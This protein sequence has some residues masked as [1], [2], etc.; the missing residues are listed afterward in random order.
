MK[1]NAL[2]FLPTIVLAGAAIVLTSPAISQSTQPGECVTTATMSVVFAAGTPRA[3]IDRVIS[4]IR[5]KELASG[6]TD[7]QPAGRWSLTSYGNTGSIGTACRF[8]YSFVPDGVEVPDQ[9]LGG[10]PSSLQGTFTGQFGS[11][12]LWKLK[13]RQMF[14]RW[15]ELS[16]L[17]Y[18]EVSDDGAPLHFFPG[19][20]GMRGDLRVA[21]IVMS[22]PNVLA[23]NFY[24][25]NGDMVV[26]LGHNWAV[27]GNDYRFMRNILGH[28]HGHGMG[29]AHVMPM[30]ETKLME[31]VLTVAFDG[32]QDDD[33]Q[34][35]QFLYG[36]I[37]EDND[38]VAHATDIGL[39]SSGQAVE[40]LAVERPAD[41]DWFRVEIPA[42]FN[43]TVRVEPVGS[44][45][46]VGPQGGTPR[47][48]NGR[49]VNNLRL[50][51]YSS[52]GTV[53]LGSSNVGGLGFPETLQSISRPASGFVTVKVDVSTISEDI[54]RYRLI[55][56][57]D[58]ATTTFSPNN[59]SVLI[60]HEVGGG[61]FSLQV[62]DDER[63]RLHPSPLINPNNAAV[64]FLVMSTST[65][66]TPTA[67]VIGYE[68][69]ASSANI[70]RT[71]Y[72]WDFV[73]QTWVSL[74]SSQA[75]LIE[76]TFE[77]NVANPARFVGPG[78]E[79]RMR[80]HQVANGPIFAFPYEMATDW[81]YWRLSQ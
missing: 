74:N 41:R 8:G 26:N 12:A 60:G 22:E 71:I 56:L 30:S 14:D 69:A 49:A 46:L 73:S 33:I 66:Q 28:E 10:G 1:L 5:K 42:G 11:V 39:V 51:A 70:L 18:D 19:Q 40:I 4:N 2:K 63:L 50:S 43:L 31:P 58:G 32:P 78:G 59:Y 75:N 9:G 7:Y 35:C 29:L 25:N 15:G 47:L 21:G 38:D 34:G 67:M 36:D 77:Y 79:M 65:I 17:R 54:Q 81:V 64:D 3:E 23:Y 55:F 72:A 80:V 57:L 53:L 62:S 48:R 44:S 52:D 13:F 27:Q 76:Q 68:G 20:L 37:V 24:P 16:G 6:M 61:L 45:Y